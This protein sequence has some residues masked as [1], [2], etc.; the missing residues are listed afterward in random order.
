MKC[1]SVR[2]TGSEVYGQIYVEHSMFGSMARSTEDDWFHW[3]LPNGF[4][5]S[6][7]CYWT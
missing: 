7:L 5:F 4:K 2:Q 3:K 1:P 6:E